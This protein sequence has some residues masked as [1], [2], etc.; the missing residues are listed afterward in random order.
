MAIERWPKNGR[1]NKK[2]LPPLGRIQ[3]INKVIQ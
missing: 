3:P 1:E 2:Q